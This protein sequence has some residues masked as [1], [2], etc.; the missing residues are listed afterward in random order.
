MKIGFDKEKYLQLQTAAILK[1][2]NMF[3][4]KLY[5][6][7]GGK[8]FDDYHASRVLPGFDPD[9]KIRL[10]EKLKDKAE[11]IFT[12]GADD[13]E[14]KKVR[15]DLGITYD[16]DL[17]RII[18]DMKKRRIIVNSVVITKYNNQNSADKFILKLK[19]NNITVYTHKYIE[20]YPFCIDTILSDNGFGANDYIVTSKPLVI[21][22]APGPGSGKLSVCL[23]QCYNDNKNNIKAGYAKF[24]TF[25]VWNL[26]LKHPVNLAYETATAD[27]DDVNMI[28][29]FHLDKYGITTVNYNRDLEVFPILKKILFNIYGKDIYYSPTDMGVNMIGNCIIDD[30]II[31]NAS[32]K[33]ILRRSCNAILDN[34]L[35]ICTTQ[36]VQKIE[37]ILNYLNIVKEDRTVV[38]EAL[39]KQEITLRSSMALELSNE[40]IITGKTTDVMTAPASLILNA[41]KY[42]CHLDDEIHLLSHDILEPM[43]KYKKKIFNQDI[44]TL[45]E[46]ILALSVCAT[47]NPLA[48]ITLNKLSSLKGLD[49]HSTT[50]LC[51]SDQNTL[52]TLGITYT[53]EPI[54][55][56]D[57][58]Y[59]STI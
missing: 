10:L 52:R 53:C 7:F 44:L 54:M 2:I 42:L 34:R 24:E 51:I 11:V 29:S 56:S 13:I 50:M 17:L 21:V 6:E 16:L 14:K 9:L 18:D 47:T 4:D 49:S 8:L 3:G 5:L 35:G 58:L 37:V 19:K 55:F 20:G 25:P 41:V 48:Q 1:R 38:V 12:I 45:Q 36:T 32:K 46:V 39:K 15:A 33:E 43:I 30:E 31:I 40:V 23:S 28:D 26:P 57:K 59:D 27:L 22:T